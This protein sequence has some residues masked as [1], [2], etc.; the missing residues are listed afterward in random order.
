MLKLGTLTLGVWNASFQVSFSS[1]FAMRVHSCTFV[2]VYTS[3]CST[4]YVEVSLASNLRCGRISIHPDSVFIDHVHLH[5][6]DAE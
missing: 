1:T 3:Y 2:A 4:E 5:H 6:A